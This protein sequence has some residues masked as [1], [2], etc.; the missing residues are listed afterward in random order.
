MLPLRFLVLLNVTVTETNWCLLRNPLVRSKVLLVFVACDTQPVCC[1][2]VISEQNRINKMKE[3]QDVRKFCRKEDP[4]HSFS[5]FLRRQKICHTT[6]RCPSPSRRIQQR[7]IHAGQRTFC[8]RCCWWRRRLPRFP[9]VRIQIFHPALILTAATIHTSSLI[10]F[11]GLLILHGSYISL[12]II[13]LV[14]KPLFG[15]RWQPA[16]N[17]QSVNAF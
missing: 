5:Y 12:T 9:C 11:V 17:W 14:N 4:K 7:K 13:G 6:D 2:C 3:A 15:F 16:A 1:V 10:P 8:C